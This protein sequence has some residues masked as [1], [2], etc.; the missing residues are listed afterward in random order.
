[1]LT[2]T[3]LAVRNDLDAAAMTTVRGGFSFSDF[4]SLFGIVNAP[5]IDLGTHL[6]SQNQALAVDQSNN[7]GGLN[8]VISDQ[9]QNGIAGQVA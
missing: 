2:I 8:L 9:T 6:L 7:I 1:M 3:D 4:D 5:E